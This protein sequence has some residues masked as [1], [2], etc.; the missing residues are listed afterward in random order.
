MEPRRV[1]P[2]SGVA[3]VV[4]AL[5]AIVG[6]GGDTPSNDASAAEVADFYSAHSTRN[7]IAA[8][9]LA[10]SIPFLVVFGVALMISNVIN[11]V[12]IG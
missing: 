7:A 8:F 2:L 12:S 6:L 5:V 11:P 10:V 3:F 4:I 9:V 1:L